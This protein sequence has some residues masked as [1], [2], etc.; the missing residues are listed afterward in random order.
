[1]SSQSISS[2]RLARRI[3]VAILSIGLS[4]MSK[5]HRIG[6]KCYECDKVILE[7]PHICPGRK[8]EKYV[9]DKIYL[10][11]GDIADI[12]RHLGIKD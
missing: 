3:R 11:L 4:N 5:L 6:D 9:I 2:L 1:M 12:D 10:T 8:Q 7:C